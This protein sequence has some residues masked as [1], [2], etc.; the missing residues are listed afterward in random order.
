MITYGRR[1]PDA[2]AVGIDGT[3]GDRTPITWAVRAA[4]AHRLPVR[5][6]HAHPHAYDLSVTDQVLAAE[7]TARSL[8]PDVMVSPVAST[9]EA[10]EVLLE[11]SAKA[12]MARRGAPRSASTP[13]A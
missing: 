5:L 9:G 11:Q 7:E 4:A 6:V 8:A 12:R 2:V 1:T 10:V 13:A 3:T